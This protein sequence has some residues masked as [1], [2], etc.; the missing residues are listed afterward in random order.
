MPFAAVSPN[1]PAV[2]RDDLFGNGQA[3]ASPA[4]SPGPG[5]VRSVEAVEDLAQV[6]ARNPQALVADAQQDPVLVLI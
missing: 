4:L 5:L 3:K 6:L 2:G 1:P